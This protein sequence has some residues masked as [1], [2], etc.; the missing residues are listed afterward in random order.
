MIFFYRLLLYGD[1]N[2]GIIPKESSPRSLYK[3]IICIL[4]VLFFNT[5]AYEKDLSIIFIYGY[6]F[7]YSMEL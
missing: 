3:Q 2:Q 4:F 5:N 1:I 7:H 6:Y